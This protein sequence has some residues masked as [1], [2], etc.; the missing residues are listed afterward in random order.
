[1][2]KSLKKYYNINSGNRAQ[3]Y[4]KMK[5]LRDL[6]L[7]HIWLSQKAYIEKIAKLANH[8]KIYLT[9]ISSNELLPNQKHA[10][11]AKIQNYQ[12]KIGLLLFATISIRP[13]I[14]FATSRLAK[15]LNNPSSAYHKAADR[16]LMYLYNT[17]QLFLRFGGQNNL[18]VASDASFANNNTNRKS[19][20]AF[21]IKLF[22]GL[23]GW[24]ANKQDTVITLTTEAELLALAQAAKKSIYLSKL[25]QKLIIDL[26]D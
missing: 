6:P 10:S 18:V 3:W 15:F 19:L 8:R 16:A 20:Q 9:L 22:S 21:A 2:I 5:I 24:R 7:E 13:N 23:I 11:P 26:N 17:R 25:L 12:R 14:A 1:L 4:L